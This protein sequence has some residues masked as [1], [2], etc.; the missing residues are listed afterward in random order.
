MELAQFKEVHKKIAKLQHGND[1]AMHKDA[2]VV[3]GE[4][5]LSLRWEKQGSQKTVRRYVKDPERKLGIASDEGGL[6]SAVSG[7]VS[8]NQGGYK[9]NTS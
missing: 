4:E 6:G 9:Y 1:T 8:V 7:T 3:E 2:E 5:V